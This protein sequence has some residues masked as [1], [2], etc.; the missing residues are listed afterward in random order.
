VILRHPRLPAEADNDRK[1]AIEFNKVSVLKHKQY[2]SRL[3]PGITRAQI[4][5]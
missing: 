5:D 4:Q 1:Q 3:T 2:I